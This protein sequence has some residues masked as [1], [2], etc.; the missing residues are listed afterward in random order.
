ML[1]AFGKILGALFNRQVLIETLL[2]AKLILIFF[3]VI[4][5]KNYS[6]LFLFT[7]CRLRKMKSEFLN[8]PE[9]AQCCSLADIVPPFQVCTHA[10]FFYIR[11]VHFRPQTAGASRGGRRYWGTAVSD[12]LEWFIKN[13]QIKLKRR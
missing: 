7:Y 5:S 4:I 1:T 3:L 2:P 8:I 11:K 13:L 12:K 9:L 6:K 10:L